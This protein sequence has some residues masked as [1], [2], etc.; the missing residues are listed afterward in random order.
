MKFI[1]FLNGKNPETYLDEQLKICKDL[2]ELPR[3]LIRCSCCSRHR[4]DFPVLSRHN[5]TKAYS[6]NFEEKI[7]KC[8]CRHF[9]RHLC[10]KWDIIHEVNDT[11]DE[12]SSSDE[13]SGS[14]EDF[15]VRD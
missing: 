12:E 15:I 1:D 3:E 4:F 2:D 6:H 10:K 11:S 14:L 9:A 8:P 13:S 7:C 5:I